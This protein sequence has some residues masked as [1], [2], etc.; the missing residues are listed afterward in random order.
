MQSKPK[1]T[2]VLLATLTVYFLAF[3][4][5]VKGVADMSS[6]N[7]TIQG[8]NFN[9]TSGSKESSNY[10]IQDVVGATSGVE[11][12]S[13]GYLIS[14]GL[15]FLSGIEPFTFSISATKI[16]FGDLS[17]NHPLT[18]QSQIVIQNGI[19]NGFLVYVGEKSPLSTANQAAIPDTSCD[20]TKT[21][22]N[23]TRAE[24]WLKSSTFGFG[25]GMVGASIK[26]DFKDTSYFRP[27]ADLSQNE[28]LAVIMESH[29]HKTISQAT[30]NY[31]VNVSNTQSVGKYQNT[32]SFIAIPGY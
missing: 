9:M 18:K 5:P 1:I 27:F 22:C 23:S 3:G 7:Y 20:N 32:I 29:A 17:P 25:F 10:K 14:T 4:A 30:I 2:A 28:P 13:L 24:P 16:D 11:F 15:P 6:E 12:N 31:K 19:S 26:P 21:P 8:G